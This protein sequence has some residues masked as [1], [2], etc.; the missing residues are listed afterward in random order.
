MARRQSINPSSSL[1]RLTRTTKHSVDEK[2]VATEALAV[3][4]EYDGY[5]RDTPATEAAPAP[6]P[7]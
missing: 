2:Y 1:I 6:D 5:V 3:G 4:L 7:S